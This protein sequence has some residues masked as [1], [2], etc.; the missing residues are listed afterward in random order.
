MTLKD[1]ASIAKSFD[2]LSHDVLVRG[3]LIFRVE[4]GFAAFIRPEPG[5]IAITL[6]VFVNMKLA[7]DVSAQ[8]NGS[9]DYRSPSFWK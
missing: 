8:L 6:I 7:L 9:A 5:D 2:F 3:L 1:C 4:E